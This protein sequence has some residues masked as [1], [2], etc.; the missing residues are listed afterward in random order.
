MEVFLWCFTTRTPAGHWGE[1]SVLSELS[2]TARPASLVLYHLMRLLVPRR[3]ADDEGSTPSPLLSEDPQHHL[4]APY[5]CRTTGP[6][7][8]LCHC[9]SSCMW[10]R[11]QG[12]CTQMQVLQTLSV[13]R[14]AWSTHG[15]HQWFSNS[16]PRQKRSGTLN[17]LMPR[18]GTTLIKS[19]FRN[20]TQTKSSFECS[21]VILMLQH[22]QTSGAIGGSHQNPRRAC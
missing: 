11:P 20:K 10:T 7:T 15:P 1:S 16:A 9:F 21:R 12:T 2:G 8:A 18:P 17:V 13:F 19:D 3:A 4:G 14:R 6:P 5:K 22:L